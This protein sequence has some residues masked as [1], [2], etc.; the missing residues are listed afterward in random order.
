M[1][2]E[3]GR[4]RDGVRAWEGCDGVRA[5]EGHDGAREHHDGVRE[6]LQ[7]PR[8]GSARRLRLGGDVA[9]LRVIRD[10]SVWEELA[11]SLGGSAGVGGRANVLHD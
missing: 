1:V 4:E 6:V 9:R 8:F 3:H 11:W 5:L 7:R 10:E 2:S